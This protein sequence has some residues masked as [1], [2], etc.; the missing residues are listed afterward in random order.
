M[1]LSGYE[2]IGLHCCLLLFDAC[3]LYSFSLALWSN[4]HALSAT[5]AHMASG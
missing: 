3:I 2:Q 5:I 1:R 4:L